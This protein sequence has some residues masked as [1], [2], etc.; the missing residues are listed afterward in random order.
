[1]E[2]VKKIEIEYASFTI[3]FLPCV[4]D[5]LSLDKLRK[6]EQDGNTE[7]ISFDS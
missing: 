7:T 1:M 3:F 6:S 4:C 5:I 2:T